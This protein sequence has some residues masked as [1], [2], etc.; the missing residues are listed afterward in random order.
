M[1]DAAVFAHPTLSSEQVQRIV[2]RPHIYPLAMAADTVNDKLL[3][4]PDWHAD[5]QQLQLPVPVDGLPDYRLVMRMFK[6]DNP[7]QEFELGISQ[8]GNY[9][10]LLK[11]SRRL[12]TGKKFLFETSCS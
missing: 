7:E 9:R 5:I 11:K 8:G 4:V 1:Y 12:S 2:E 6:S 3:Y 10:L